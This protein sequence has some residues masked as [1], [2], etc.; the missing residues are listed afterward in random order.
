TSNASG[1]GY[2]NTNVSVS[3]K[4]GKEKDFSC[5]QY[6]HTIGVRGIDKE[7]NTEVNADESALV[8][9]DYFTGIKGF[10]GAL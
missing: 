7:T 10:Q 4:V 6:H 9:F 3:E 8:T 1:I 2:Y 5:V